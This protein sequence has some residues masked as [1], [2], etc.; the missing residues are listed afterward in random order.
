[1]S[2]IWNYSD[3]YEYAKRI[4]RAE[5]PPLIITV[6][7]TGGGAGKERN[8]YLPETIDEQV[9]STYEAYKAGAASVH[10]HARDETGTETS[11]DPARYRELN[12]RIRE[13]CPDMIIGNT[14]GVSPWDE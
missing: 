11:T 7:I 9:I 6:A 3:A 14:T 10:V 4:E 8:P 12:K 13:K 5:M 1:M 2:G